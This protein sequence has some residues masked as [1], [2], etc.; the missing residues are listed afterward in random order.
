MELDPQPRRDQEQGGGAGPSAQKRSRAGRWSWT[1][2]PE[3]IKSREVELDP[4]P[5]R[6][7]EQGGGA[8]PSAQKRAR[9]GRWSWTLSPEESKS[10]EVELDPQ[11]RRGHEQGG[12]DG[13]RK[14]GFFRRLQ[15]VVPQQQCNGHCLC[16]SAQARQLKQQLRGAQVAAQWRGDTALTLPSFWR[17]STVS[18]VFSGGIRGRAFTLFSPSP[19]LISILASAVDVKQNGLVSAADIVS[20]VPDSSN[21]TFHYR[22]SGS[23]TAFSVFDPFTWYDLP[24]PLKK[25]L[26]VCA[27]VFQY[28]EKIDAYTVQIS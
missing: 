18:P 26:C 27:R 8:G 10:R 9:A 17:R 4:Q 1:L 15:V 21:Q 22:F 19:S 23:S 3:E 13:L 28:E 12:G 16:H 24:L 25:K 7:Q 11:P 20:S 2:S 5:R 14:L 6:D